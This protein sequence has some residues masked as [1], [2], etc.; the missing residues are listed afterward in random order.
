LRFDFNFAGH[1]FK[2]NIK[3]QISDICEGGDRLCLASR[4]VN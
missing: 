2:S 4:F 3:L 1:A